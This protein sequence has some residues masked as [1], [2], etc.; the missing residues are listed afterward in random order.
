MNTDKKHQRNR[1]RMTRIARI[2]TD[3]FIRG[4]Q[5]QPLR[6]LTSPTRMA[7]AISGDP[8]SIELALEGKNRYQL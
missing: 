6:Q 3:T 8:R 7:L 2:F 4:Y 1:T 5:R